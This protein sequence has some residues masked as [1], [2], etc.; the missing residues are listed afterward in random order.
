MGPSKREM[1]YRIQC[2]ID[3]HIW[4]SVYNITDWWIRQHND[5]YTCCKLANAIQ[6]GAWNRVCGG[7]QSFWKI[8]KLAMGWGKKQHR[9]LD[10]KLK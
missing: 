6:E 9:S 8:F 3:E 10:N 5:P 1:K 2:W 4:K 7:P